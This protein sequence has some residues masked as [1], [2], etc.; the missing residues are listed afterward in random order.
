MFGD[1]VMRSGYWQLKGGKK[2]GII[3]ENIVWYKERWEKGYIIEKMGKNVYGIGN[4][5]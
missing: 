5:G 1:L 4:I 3:G 2:D